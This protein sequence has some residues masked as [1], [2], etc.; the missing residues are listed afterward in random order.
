MN[1][2]NSKAES[3][4]AIARSAAG[5]RPHSATKRAWRHVARSSIAPSSPPPA[6]SCFSSA[7]TEIDTSSLALKAWQA[8][9]TVAV[10][11]SQ[12]EP[13]TNDARR[14]H[15]SHQRDHQHGTGPR[16]DRRQADHTGFD[17]PGHCARRRGSR[18][19]A[20]A[21]VAVWASM[22]ASLPS[23]ISGRFLRTWV[24][25]TNCSGVAGP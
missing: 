1:G 3:T 8:G 25:G 20:I 11:K 5:S 16:T 24:R 22:I 7:P 18:P 4:Q 9:K 12:L 17:R 6:S 10:P 14:D 23:L 13:A 2:M 21:S 19:A 15:Q